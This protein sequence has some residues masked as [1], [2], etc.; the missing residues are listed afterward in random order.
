MRNT[1][2]S[3]PGGNEAEMHFGHPQLNGS[4][5]SQGHSPPARECQLEPATEAR[6]M[7][8]GERRHS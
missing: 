5:R 2:D 1:R 3:S 8:H 6:T 4:G 7:N